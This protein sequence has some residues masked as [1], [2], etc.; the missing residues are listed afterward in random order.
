MNR[1]LSD[2]TVNTVHF[3]ST[4]RLLVILACMHSQITCIYVRSTGFKKKKSFLY[5]LTLA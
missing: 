5:L 4:V 1:Q 2:M 3:N